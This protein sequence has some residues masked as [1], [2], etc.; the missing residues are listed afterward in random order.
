M[1][2]VKKSGIAG[3]GVFAR[4]KIRKGTRIIEYKGTRK[5]ES[6]CPD[7]PDSYVD[8]F[9]VG[10]GIVIDPKENGNEA[11]FI[12]HSCSPNCEAIQEDNRIY[13]H[14]MRTIREGEELNYDYQLSLG[15]RPTARDRE[16]YKC[17][18]GSE[19]CIG[20][21]YKP[22]KKKRATHAKKK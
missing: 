6:E 11:R 9:D 7:N 15:H 16:R 10:R 17:K 22:K 1:I 12:N 13:I 14:S 3:K 21:I 5:K 2:Y 8:L 18:C 19:K 20:T 4:R